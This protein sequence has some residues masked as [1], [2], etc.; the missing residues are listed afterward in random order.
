MDEIPIILS[1]ILLSAFFSGIEIAYISANK[2]RIELANKQGSLNGRILSYF[3]KQPSQFIGTL[4]IGNN[5][6]LVVYGIFMAHLLTPGLINIIPA[7][8]LSEASL[9]LFQTIISTFIILITAEFLPKVLFRINPNKTLNFFAIPALFFYALLYP[10][11]WIIKSFSEWVLKNFARVEFPEKKNIFGRVDLD[12]F[13]KEF[14]P[15]DNT[16]PKH[17][18][19]IQMFQNVLDFNSVKVRE[20]MVPRT[21]I[22]ASNIESDIESLVDM[23]VKTGVSKILIYKDSIDNIIGFVHSY[24]MFKKPRT[25]NHAGQRIAYTF[26][27]TAQIHRSCRR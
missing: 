27:P 26:H 4:L 10:L 7:Q 20:C 8:F 16:S 13:L 21:E 9:L 22:L 19:E 18:S 15:D 25:G 17:Q 24:E 23:F 6:C 3:V 5:I 1:S 2:F 14:A 11:V 12:H